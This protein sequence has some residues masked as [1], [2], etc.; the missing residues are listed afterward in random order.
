MGSRQRMNSSFPILEFDGEPEAIIEPSKVIKPIA[1][2][3]RCVLPIYHTVIAKLL[4]R[5]AIAARDRYP[6]GHGATARVQAGS[7]QHGSHGSA[8]RSG[9]TSRGRRHGGVDRPW[10][11]ASSSPVAARA[12]SIL[13][14]PRARSLC[15]RA[16]FGT[17]ARPITT[18]L[19]PGKLLPIRTSFG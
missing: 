14:W 19:R 3:E 10:D 8:S 1:I 7:R 12:F 13:R 11:A 18:L 6:Y 5:L 4:A 2:P 9:R 16:P 17:K 15:R